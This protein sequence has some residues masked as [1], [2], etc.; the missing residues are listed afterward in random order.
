MR[1]N[2][3][4]KTQQVKRDPYQTMLRLLI[5]LAIFVMVG[6]GVFFL[7]R[8]LI[9]NEV[10]SK[11]IE[12][13]QQNIEAEQKFTAEINA[14][15]SQSNP[16]A[17]SSLPEEEEGDL[18]FWEKS[19]DGHLWRI[20]SEGRAG[21]E[22][23]STVSLDRASVLYGGLM[24]INAWHPV[25]PDFFNPPTV[26]VGTASNY[27][28]QVEDAT[29]E[30][31]PVAFDALSAIVEEGVKEGFTTYIAREGFRSL[32]T[33][34]AMFTAQQ[35]RL[36]SSYSG[37]S[38]IEQTKRRVNYPGTS[39]YHSGLSVRMDI[40]PMKDNVKFQQSDSGKWFTENS[41]KYGFVFRFPV[42]DFPSPEWEDKSYKTGVST[43]L[44]LYRYVGKA[45][46]AAMRIMDFCLEEYVE[47]L[48]QNPHICIYED[49][50]LKY[51]IFRIPCSE[52]LETYELPVPNPASEYQ[53]SLDNM[54]GMVMAYY[55]H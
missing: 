37:N 27:K 39:D 12:I 19:L 22:N 31:L 34:T 10:T 14:A 26:G 2:A 35:E 54:D 18:P 20:E 52:V 7:C 8:I 55:Y 5:I 28:M 17:V 9:Q 30:L 40:Y 25:P 36:S 21:L 44:N 42:V 38:L 43:A 45:H 4:R 53:A 16:F 32:E 13:E 33:Q 51:E 48:I 41:W 49:G 3:N 11:R 24:L 6:F 1:G 15:R 50:A 23:T 46:A 47:F 29:V